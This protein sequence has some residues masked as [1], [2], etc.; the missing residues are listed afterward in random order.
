[1][2]SGFILK[3]DSIEKNVVLQF[4]T[5]EKKTLRNNLKIRPSAI[6][7]RD[8]GVTKG[9]NKST[10]VSHIDTQGLRLTAAGQHFF[11]SD[12][13]ISIEIHRVHRGTV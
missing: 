7:V 12:P 5:T 9:A 3:F 13:D 1:M 2:S 4:Q 10:S 8:K 6:K 11:C